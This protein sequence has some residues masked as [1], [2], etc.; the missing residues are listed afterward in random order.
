MRVGVC[1]DGVGVTLGDGVFE[2]VTVGLAVLLAVGESVR[3][4]RVVGVAVGWG[5]LLGCRVDVALGAT[6]VD[7]CVTL[8][9]GANVS[10]T[11]ALEGVGLGSRVGD[12]VEDGSG[13]GLVA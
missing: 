3:L 8:A 11:T 7:T 9:E 12:D 10:T 4:A 13:V 1:G 5:V 2:G 6:V